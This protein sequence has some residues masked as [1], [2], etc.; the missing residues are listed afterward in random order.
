MRTP[1]AFA[2]AIALLATTTFA[3][4]GPA[5]LG[6]GGDRVKPTAAQKRCLA[7]TRRVERQREVI[8][9]ADARTTRERSARQACRTRRACDS[10]DRALKAGEARRVRYAKQLAQFEAEAS[11]ICASA[12]GSH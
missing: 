6:E 7:A 9:E 5:P 10:L 4:D 3:A 2:L 1:I 12:T 8:T 11:T